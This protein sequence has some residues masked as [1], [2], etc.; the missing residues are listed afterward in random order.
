MDHLASEESWMTGSDDHDISSKCLFANICSRAITAYDSCSG[1]YEHERHRLPHDIG[2][3]DDDDIF[4]AYV[5]PIVPEKCHDPLRST[6]PES[7]LAEIHVPDLSLGK[8]IDILPRIDALRHRIAVY[9]RG[10]RSLDDEPM[11]TIIT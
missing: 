3:P 2:S 11:D 6:A 4:P 10:E 7:I 8:S 5:Y 9:M 1:I